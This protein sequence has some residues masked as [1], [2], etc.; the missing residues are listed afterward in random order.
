[1]KF[2]SLFGFS[3][4]KKGSVLF[5]REGQETKKRL[6]VKRIKDIYI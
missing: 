5:D 2:V 6:I 4:R 3:D 1:M